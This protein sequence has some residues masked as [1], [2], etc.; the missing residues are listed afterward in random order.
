MYICVVL[1]LI[2]LKLY[3]NMRKIITLMLCLAAVM[4]ASA[5]KPLFVGHRGCNRGVENTVEAYRNGVDYYGYDGLECDVRVT[6]DKKYVIS[7]DETTERVGG[8]LTV[9]NATLEQLQAENYTQTR[10]GV[11]YTGKI[12]TMAEYLD[13]CVEKGVFPVI[14]LKWTTGINSNDMSN[15]PGLAALIEEKGLTD[16]AIILTSMKPSLEYVRT[17]YPALKCQWLCNANW[18]DNEPWCQQWNLEPSISTGN[19]DIYTVKKFHDLGLDVACWVVDTE[20]SYKSIGAMGVKM[21]TC[22]SL[23]PSSMP[24]LADIDWDAVVEPVQPLELKCDT[25]FKYSRFRGDLPENFPSGLTDESAYNSAQMAAMY[26]GMFYPNNYS[27][28][29]LLAF[30][31]DGAT[32]SGLPGGKSQGVT[33]DDAGNL[34]VRDDGATQSSPNKMVLYREGDVTP[35]VVNFELLNPG[36]THFISASGDVFSEEGGYVYFFPYTQNVVNVVKIADGK[37]VE[38]TASSKLSLTGSTAGVVYPINN[39]PN[40][41]IYQ[42]RS[43]GYYL[44]DNGDKGAYVAGSAST[45][46]PNRNSSV[47]GAYFTMDGHELFL[48]SSGTNYNGGFTIKDMT[49]KAEP[50]LTVPPMGNGGYGANPSVGA[51]YR[52]EKLDDTHVMLYEYCMG[53]GYAAYQ[54]YLDLPYTGVNE[55]SVT[56]KT[57][58]SHTYFDLTGRASQRPFDGINIV[59]TRYSDGTTSATKI[60]R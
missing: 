50:I 57:E 47:G 45:T 13:I 53:N 29:T 17:N 38:V 12:C 49:A 46:P 3:E 34:I 21:M 60:V 27:N 36:R 42:V 9:A 22:N 54:L 1:F 58:V 59:L 10:N 8:N 51:F 35:V 26:H 33:C 28:S 4:Q 18:K 24:E 20:A 5:W 15:F 37:L 43:D 14:E 41:F 31:A 2:N 25:V 48:Y 32:E 52:T 16:K 6:S 7:H 40:K 30:D 39:N 23:M 56:S 55:E 44:Y 19:F 11:T